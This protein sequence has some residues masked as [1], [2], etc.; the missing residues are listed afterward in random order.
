MA[1]LRVQAFTFDGL[2]PRPWKNGGGVTREI[3]AGPATAAA[4][5]DDSWDWRVSVAD[6]DADGAFST[7]A[8]VDRAAALVG[9]PGLRLIGPAGRGLGFD[10]V[11]CVCR[12]PGEAP[13]DAR[14]PGAAARL[15]NVMVRRGRASAALWAESGPRS[16]TPDRDGTM[17]LFVARGRGTVVLTMEG[18]QD[19]R[20]LPA[21][22]GLCI[23]G[24][25]QLHWQPAETAS[26]LLVATLVIRPGDPEPAD[27]AST[28]PTPTRAD[29]R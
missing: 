28:G 9:G 26:V 5:A 3:L 25:R 10:R 12:F 19:R 8:G 17:I 6:I 27:V 20:E 11:G 23:H 29:T 4:S 1:P 24:V 14:L 13:L 22:S 16:V 18:P 21:G 7:F 15:L 2:E